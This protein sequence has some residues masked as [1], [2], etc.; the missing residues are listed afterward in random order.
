VTGLFSW[1]RDG[2]LK[3]D[4][5]KIFFAIPN[6]SGPENF[7]GRYYKCNFVFYCKKINHNR[8]VV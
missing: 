6:G 1:K 5:A 7:Y 2:L 4:V 3:K 8:E